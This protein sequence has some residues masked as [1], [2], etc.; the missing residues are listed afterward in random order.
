MV[1]RV[2]C[3]TLGDQTLEVFNN[4]SIKING[5]TYLSIRDFEFKNRTT[6]ESVYPF[7]LV[8]NIKA[9][10]GWRLLHLNN[11]YYEQDGNKHY[12]LSDYPIPCAR[13]KGA[14]KVDWGRHPFNK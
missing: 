2:V 9:M 6:L 14:K 11:V 3:Y 5:E 4:G 1:Q 8:V 13:P 7:W 10:L 12:R